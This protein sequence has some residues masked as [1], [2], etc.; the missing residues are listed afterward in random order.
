M[1]CESTFAS[2]FCHGIHLVLLRK[3]SAPWTHLNIHYPLLRGLK[4]NNAWLVRKSN[5]N[6]IQLIHYPWIDG[7]Y[8]N[9]F[10]MHDDILLWMCNLFSQLQWTGELLLLEEYD[11]EEDS[12]CQAQTAERQTN[13]EQSRKRQKE[14][15]R[16][17]KRTKS[18]ARKFETYTAT[19]THNSIHFIWQ[20]STLI[21]RGDWRCVCTACTH[22]Y[23][24]TNICFI[25]GFALSIINDSWCQFVMVNTESAIAC[26]QLSL[27]FRSDL[28]FR[29]K[30]G[31]RRSNAACLSGTHYP[32]IKRKTKWKK[33]EEKCVA[34][35]QSSRDS[36][37]ILVLCV[38]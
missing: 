21:S 37:K 8:Q 22:A 17:G 2:A 29:S 27:A 4:Q 10:N 26:R 35:P 20:I 7:G 33:N 11:S 5:N 31:Y 16:G 24:D 9:E 3:K 13:N 25:F 6:T 32:D 38:A 36:I 28:S 18:N 34:L 23:S 14:R 12:I 15:E 30:Q 1:F 19:A